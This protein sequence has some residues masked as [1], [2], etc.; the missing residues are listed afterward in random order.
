MGTRTGGFAIGFRRMGSPWQKDLK[1]LCEWARTQGFEAIDLPRTKPEDVAV[2]KAANLRMGTVDLPGGK[3]LLATDVGVRK[4]AVGKAAE[5]IKTMSGAG[6]KLFFTVIMPENPDQA[7]AE[8]HKLAVESFGEL[9]RTAQ[10]N[11]ARILIEGWPGPQN[12]NLGCN[13]ESCRALFKDTRCEAL[14]VNYDPSHLIRMGIDHVRFAEE[15]ATRIGHVHAKDTE[16]LGE[17]AYEIGLF[18]GSIQQKSHGFG[19]FAWRYTLP[20]YGI[21]RWTRICEI[22][23]AVGFK[24]AVSVEL[25]DENFNGSED[26][27]KAGL[28]ASLAY[29]KAV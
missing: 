9:G 22:L 11:G 29:L 25:E 24:G 6:A 13:P 15:F 2:L 19:G 28:L 17:N 27:E 1:A 4:E 3:A 23:V 5:F 12:A 16:I 10:E 14:G 20:G 18:Q 8:N 26:G 21:S 7:V